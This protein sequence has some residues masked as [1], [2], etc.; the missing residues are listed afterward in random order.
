MISCFE[1]T[2]PEL[3]KQVLSREYAICKLLTTHIRAQGTSGHP[4]ASP[5]FSGRCFS[6][7]WGAFQRAGCSPDS[8]LT[9]AACQIATAHRRPARV[10]PRQTATENV[11]TS[12]HCVYLRNSE[13]FSTKASQVASGPSP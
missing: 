2:K 6:C 10:S 12:F 13:T 1:G 3:E 9:L 7:V 8:R 5:T 11:N 4:R